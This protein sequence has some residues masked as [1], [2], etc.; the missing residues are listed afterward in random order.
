[1]HFLSEASF[2][3]V[4]HINDLLLLGDTWVAFG[5]LSSCVARQHPYFVLW[6]YKQ[7]FFLKR[8]PYVIYWSMGCLHPPTGGPLGPGA[9]L[10]LL[11]L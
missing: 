1:M 8:K 2:Q 6:R 3:H 11:C 9:R 10:R 5:I 4:M 7:I